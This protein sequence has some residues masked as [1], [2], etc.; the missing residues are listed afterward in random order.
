MQ[1]TLKQ[2]AE[3]TG[4]SKQAIQQAIKSGKVSAK[5][6][7]FNEWEIDPAEL[8]RVYQPVKRLDT[9]RKEQVDDTW[10]SEPGDLP[11]NLQTSIIK[12]SAN[13]D[14]K[15]KEI[16]LLEKR[17]SELVGERDNWRE[18]AQRLALT[19]QKP[20][21]N[22]GAT[23]VTPPPTYQIRLSSR[24]IWVVIGGVLLVVLG[25]VLGSGIVAR[26]SR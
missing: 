10:P 4:R 9:S 25:V 19:Y 7:D 5:K 2:A 26:L 21:E 11:E 18:Q 23:L 13:L 12:L 6:N 20:V 24:Q 22:T 16:A 3:E 8:F 17:A 15:E 14:A 1:L